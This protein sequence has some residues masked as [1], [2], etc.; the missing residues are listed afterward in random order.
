MLPV[1]HTLTK[2]RQVKVTYICIM[3]S[4]HHAVHESGK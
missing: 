1:Q 4:F 3:V 2:V